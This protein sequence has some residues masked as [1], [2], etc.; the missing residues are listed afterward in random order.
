MTQLDKKYPL[1]NFAKNKGYG[2]AQHLNALKEFGYTSIHRKSF[3][4]VVV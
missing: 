3:K 2:T 4:G 1:Y